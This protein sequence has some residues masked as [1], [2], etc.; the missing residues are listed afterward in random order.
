MVVN[1]ADKLRQRALEV[2]DRPGMGSLFGRSLRHREAVGTSSGYRRSPAKRP[3]PLPN[4]VD[5]EV[6]GRN[7]EMQTKR[8]L[9]LVA[10]VTLLLVSLTRSLSLANSLRREV[11][12]RSPARAARSRN[13]GLLDK[14]GRVRLAENL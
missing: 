8:N 6:R 13:T 12:T 7:A 5:G 11:I 14:L 9:A 2:V 4:E 3:E 10:R 1:D